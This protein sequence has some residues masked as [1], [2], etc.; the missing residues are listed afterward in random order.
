MGIV[1]CTLEVAV[2]EVVEKKHWHDLI[3]TIC[4]I[5]MNGTIVTRDDRD[6]IK[7]P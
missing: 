7:K 1:A 4:S 2:A 5:T 3:S 6:E